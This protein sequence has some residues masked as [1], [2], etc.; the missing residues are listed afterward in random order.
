MA[1]QSHSVGQLCAPVRCGAGGAGRLTSW[2][3]APGGLRLWRSDAPPERAD[4]GGERHARRDR[5][6]ADPAEKPTPQIARRRAGPAPATGLDR[7]RPAQ[8][9]LRSGTCL[10]SPAR[11]AEPRARMHAARGDA[12]GEAGR[13]GRHC[14]LRPATLVASPALPLATAAGAAR[15]FRPR[16]LAARYRVLATDRRNQGIAHGF[17]LRRPVPEGGRHV[18]SLTT[19]QF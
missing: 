6:A 13:K 4:R 8:R 5:R 14:R 16:A 11:A 9:S 2:T 3:D 15:A 1:G 18:L 7:P 19:T 10:L 12:G 17:V